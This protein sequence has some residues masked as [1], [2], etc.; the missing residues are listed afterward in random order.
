MSEDALMK[1]WFAG[2]LVGFIPGFFV[3]AMFIEWL[4]GGSLREKAVE[5][6]AAEWV[7]NQRDGTTTFKWKDELGDKK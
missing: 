6:G 3:G 4:T 5:V 2:L 1:E 7:V